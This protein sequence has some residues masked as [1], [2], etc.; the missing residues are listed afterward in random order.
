MSRT[1]VGREDR[2][3]HRIVR[4]LRLA[5]SYDLKVRVFFEHPAGRVEDRWVRSLSIDP[6]RVRR[7]GDKRPGYSCLVAG[8][9]NGEELA[10]NSMRNAVLIPREDPD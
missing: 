10:V 3:V 1:A 8:F 9:E 6:H 4:R 2:S 7:Q 5:M